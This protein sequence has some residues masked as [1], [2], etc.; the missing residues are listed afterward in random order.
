MEIAMNVLQIRT[1]VARQQGIIRKAAR[2]VQSIC[3]DEPSF[4]EVRALVASLPC[5]RWDET[6]RVASAVY[7]EVQS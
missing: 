7:A 5:V 3:P 1:A 2:A 4:N 6:E